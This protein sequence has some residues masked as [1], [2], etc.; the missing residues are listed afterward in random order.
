MEFY[1]SKFDEKDFWNRLRKLNSL[2][3][4]DL[5]FFMMLKGTPS[6]NYS[7]GNIFPLNYLS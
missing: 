7:Y 5:E 2:T 6:K 4:S 3:D 1:D